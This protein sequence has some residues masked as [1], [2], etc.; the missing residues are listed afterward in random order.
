MSLGEDLWH[1]WPRGGPKGL[2]K[3]LAI[4][5]WQ[6]HMYQGG[7]GDLCAFVAET[8]GE[9]QYLHPFLGCAVSVPQ[10]AL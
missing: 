7:S 6:I 3:A 8:F 4:C 2:V 5:V 1:Q 9:A 10:K